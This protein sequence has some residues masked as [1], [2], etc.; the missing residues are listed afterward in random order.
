MST[1]NIAIAY[2]A[3]NEQVVKQIEQ[4]LSSS[5]Y[6]FQHFVGTK[7]TAG[8][9]LADQLLNQPNPIL[10]IV[11]DN[12]LKA[13]QCMQHGL[14]LLQ[15]KRNQIL[16]VV[17]EGLAEDEQTGKPLKIQTDFERVSD[18]IQYINYWQDQY[19]D[20]RR[21]KRQMKDFDENAFNTHLKIMREISSEAG[22]FLR[23]LRGMNYLTHQELVDNSFEHF[24]KF[25][26]DASGWNRFKAQG[27]IYMPPKPTVTEEEEEAPAEEPTSPVVEETEKNQAEPESAGPPVEEEQTEEE[28]IPVNLADIPGID[29]IEELQ[30]EAVTEP[31][32]EEPQAVAPVEEEDVEEEAP[33][34]EIAD[35]IASGLEDAYRYAPPAEE[36]TTAEVETEAES[37][38]RSLS[39]MQSEEILQPVE[40]D[41]D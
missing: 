1:K 35:A 28:Q 21:Q 37:T 8:P 26:D 39:A 25:T 3:D 24:F 31:V 16:P 41:E 5:G 27:A 18:I 17:I 20:L 4:Q 12:Y 32:Q 33:K 19:L 40:E 34:E 29:L 38:A 9:P 7:T 10:L 14:K 36:I 11:S 2:C 23:V 30:E 6:E 15:E 22:E 13:A